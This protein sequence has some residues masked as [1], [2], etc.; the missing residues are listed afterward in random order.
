MYTNEL[1]TL[2][3]VDKI[4]AG[5]IHTD[6]PQSVKYQGR[7]RLPSVALSY[8]QEKGTESHSIAGLAWEDKMRTRLFFLVLISS[9]GYFTLGLALAWPASALPSIRFV[10][11]LD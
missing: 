6:L 7:T 11:I 5:D 3:T 1:K 8:S 2:L 10:R 9:F 4:K